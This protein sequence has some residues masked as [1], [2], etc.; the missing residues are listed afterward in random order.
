MYRVNKQLYTG[1]KI[2][3]HFMFVKSPSFF[4]LDD[5]NSWQTGGVVRQID[6]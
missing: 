1:Q 3:P 4:L 6:I 5:G 2:S